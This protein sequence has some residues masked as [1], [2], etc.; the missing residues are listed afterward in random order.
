[1]QNLPYPDLIKMDIEGMESV[2]LHACRDII[3]DTQRPFW[4]LSM[5]EGHFGLSKDYPGWT[6][7]FDFSIFQDF[8]RIYDRHMNEHDRLGGFNEYFL[9]PR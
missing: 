9:I 4:Q 3:T 1:M 6:G 2:A 7:S 5:H 8:Y